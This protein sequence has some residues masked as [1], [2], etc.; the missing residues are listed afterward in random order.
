[1]L[2][3]TAKQKIKKIQNDL[4]GKTQAQSEGLM[5]PTNTVSDV[6]I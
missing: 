4:A 5:T 3:R 6:E 2:E 1:M